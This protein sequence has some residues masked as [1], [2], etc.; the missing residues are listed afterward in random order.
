MAIEAPYSKYRKQNCLIFIIVF[1]VLSAWCVYDGY[2]ND[3]WIT[4]HTNE[5]GTPQPYLT[6]NRQA[7]TALYRL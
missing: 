1:I 2:L 5:D 3:E 4:E 6:F 7:L